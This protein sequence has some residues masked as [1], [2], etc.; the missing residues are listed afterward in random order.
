LHTNIHLSDFDVNS[1]SS[2]LQVAMLW[3]K[4][5]LRPGR[6]SRLGIPHFSHTAVEHDDRAGWYSNGATP[7]RSTASERRFTAHETCMGDLYQR[8]P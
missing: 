3:G 2:L 7:H 4:D 1:A 8:S 5:C 6:L